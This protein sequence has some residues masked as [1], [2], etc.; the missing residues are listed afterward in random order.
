LDIEGSELKALQ[1]MAQIIKRDKPKLAISLYH[2]TED[3]WTLPLFIK[4]LVPEYK[5]FVRHHG[6][7]IFGKVL[8]ATL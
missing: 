3:L 2:K 1:G 5:L 8:Y 6:M 4:S 7:G